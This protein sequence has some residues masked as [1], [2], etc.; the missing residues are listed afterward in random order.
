GEGLRGR[1]LRRRARMADE[2]IPSP[3]TPRFHFWG[4]LK[5]M[6][7]VRIYLS[8]ADHEL[9]FR[10]DR[11]VMTDANGTALPAPFLGLSP[12]VRD[13]YAA[14]DFYHSHVELSQAELD[15]LNALSHADALKLGVQHVEMGLTNR[16]TKIVLLKG[17]RDLA[18][19]LFKIDHRDSDHPENNYKVTVY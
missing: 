6:A 5:P 7:D 3:F 1:C 4:T 11:F 14:Y 15:T 16:L 8:E 12:L 2:A 17:C 19:E 18:H 9:G 10:A 13:S